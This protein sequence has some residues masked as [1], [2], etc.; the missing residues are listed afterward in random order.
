MASQND[1]V[2]RLRVASPCPANWQRMSGDDRIRFCDLCN[3]QVYNIS[4]MTRKEIE[5]LFANTEGRICAR[6]FRRIDGTII[7]KDCPMGLRAVRQ[8]LARVALAVLA[9]IVSL[10]ATVMGQKPIRKDK[11]SC[12]EQVAVTKSTTES[13][14]EPRSISGTVVDPNGE[15][16]QGVKV[17]VTRKNGKVVTSSRSDDRGRFQVRGLKSDTYE[18]ILELKGFALLKVTEIRLGDKDEVIVAAILMPSGITELIGI[19]AE[20]QP[21]LDRDSATT[22]TILSGDLIRRL[23]H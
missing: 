19:V 8:R 16:I 10:A 12:Q 18:L 13:K 4:Q 14:Q 1:R 20:E 21:L 22:K 17:R 2:N 5:T 3:L 15:F 23:P 6:L 11:S 9:A 7:T